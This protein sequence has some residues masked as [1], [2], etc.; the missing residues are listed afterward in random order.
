VVHHGS[1][2]SAI[3]DVPGTDLARVAPS[4]LDPSLPRLLA[5]PLRARI[6][7]LL[8]AEQLCTC[9]L[10][11]L[12]GA[13]Q[14]NVSNHLRALREAGVVTAA[15]HGRYTYYRLEAAALRSLGA[16]LGA[17]ADAAE[18]TAERRRP[19]S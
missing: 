14:T 1:V 17:L 13:K 4:V 15:P 12:T 8:S 11:E 9:H 19:C 7:S 16:A 3:S 6:I 2:T 18:D 5:D 10:V